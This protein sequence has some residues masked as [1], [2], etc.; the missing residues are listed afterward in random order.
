MSEIHLTIDGVEA[1]GQSGQTILQVAKSA[2]VDIP[3]LCHHPMVSDLGGCRLCLVEVEKMR[4]FQTACTCP[5]TEGMIVHTETPK[6]A[7]TRSLVLQLLFYERNHYCMYCP[8][9]G[10][11]ELQDLAYRYDLDHWLFERPAENKDVDASRRYFVMDHNRC[12]L[13][14][15]C[16]RVCDE[17][18]ANHTLQMA[19]RGSH[20]IVSADLGLPFG[21][22]TCVSCGTCLQSCPTGALVDRR[23]VYGGH[24]EQVDR[25]PTTCMQCSVGCQIEVVSAHN[26]LLRVEGVWEAE[27]TNGLLCVD[28]RFAPLYDEKRE[29]VTRPLVRRDGALVEA[30]WNEALDAAAAGLRQGGVVGLATA[31]N[32]NE[33]LAAFKTTMAAAKG[34][35]GRIGKTLPCVKASATAAVTDIPAADLVIIAGA[36]PLEQNRVLGYLAKRAK[37]HEAKIVLV[38]DGENTMAPFADVK[39]TSAEVGQLAGLVAEAKQP[40]VLYGAELTDAAKG[41]LEGLEA[42]FLGIEPGRNGRGMADLGIAPLDADGAKARLLLLGEEKV[43]GCCVPTQNGAFTVAVASYRSDVVNEADVV[44]PAPIWAE[45]S[46]HVTN[47]EGRVLA[48]NSAVTM[49]KGVRDEVDTLADLASRL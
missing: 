33:A 24:R 40:V 21:E 39:L 43:C 2:G 4:G 48:L 1:V 36:D 41:A 44:L 29:R 14:R 19:F 26:R 35:V 6:L 7:E 38:A 15:R 23:S 42:K 17:V 49:P 3:T 32:T 22:S 10:E 45:R 27:P 5:A 34:K 31:A 20:S 13:C 28:G 11:C 46:G 37:D 8:A 30:S 18:V 9:S 12:V 25:T 47:L 16:I